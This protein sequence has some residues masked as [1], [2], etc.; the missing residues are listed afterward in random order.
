MSLSGLRIVVFESR[1]AAEMAELVRRHGGEVLS[2]PAMREVPLSESTGA[3]DFA[4]RLAAGEIDVA[5]FLTGVGTRLLFE[6]VAPSLSR[7][8]IAAALSGIVTVARGPKPRTVLREIGVRPTVLVPEPNTW[9]DLL[10]ALDSHGSI[11]GKTVAVQEYGVEN[12]ELVHAL[13]SRGAAVVRVPIYR[14]A[15]PLD[16]GPLENAIHE[17]VDGRLDV[18]LFTSATQADHLFRVAAES[19][20]AL[21]DAFESVVVGSI[22]PIASEALA[23]HGVRVDFEPEHP[24]LGYLV[25]AADER[26]PALVRARRGASG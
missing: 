4:R 22:G 11:A 14:W 8:E 5:I 18:A 3:G 6:A 20:E 12:P 9:R 26:A 15:L 21:R 17:L 2:A 10:A 7:D 13:E 16:V 1:R 23:R 24:K 19:A 25:L